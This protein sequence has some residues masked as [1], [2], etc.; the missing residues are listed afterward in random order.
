[1]GK[2][3]VIAALD[4]NN[5]CAD[6]R[7]EDFQMSSTDDFSAFMTTKPKGQGFGLLV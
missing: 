1:M 5:N 6:N 4:Y 3:N 7:V 2:Q